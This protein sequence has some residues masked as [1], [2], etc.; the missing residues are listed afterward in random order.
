[1]SVN[2]GV[3]IRTNNASYVAKCQVRQAGRI[4]WETTT[5]STTT[6]NQT[7]SVYEID[8]QDG[9]LE[10]WSWGDYDVETKD[11]FVNISNTPSRRYES[12]TG[13]GGINT[14]EMGIME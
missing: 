3:G 11:F 2:F 8:G 4:L 7:S 13:I 5:T 1:M 9:P 6:V 10:Y 12:T 14:L